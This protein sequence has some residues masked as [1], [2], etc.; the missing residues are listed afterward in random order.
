MGEKRS[1]EVSVDFG[2]QAGKPDADARRICERV[3]G[4]PMARFFVGNPGKFDAMTVCFERLADFGSE[5]S[6]RHDGPDSLIALAAGDGSGGLVL[7]MNSGD[8]S[9]PFSL[10]CRGPQP[11]RWQIID[12]GR[13]GMAIPPLAA[14][15][16]ASIVSVGCVARR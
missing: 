15:P 11:A 12:A 14:L 6:V 8:Y 13:T 4:S 1:I 16:P 9:I 7:L 2:R 5:V 10:N 3:A